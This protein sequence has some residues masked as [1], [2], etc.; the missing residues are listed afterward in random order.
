MTGEC[1]NWVSGR[2]ISRG[3]VT[4]LVVEFPLGKVHSPPYR[5]WWIKSQIQPMAHLLM[6]CDR[7]T[8]HPSGSCTRNSRA[9]HSLAASTRYRFSLNVGKKERQS[10]LFQCR[11]RWERGYRS[12]SENMHLPK[13]ASSLPATHSSLI[14]SCN[15]PDMSWKV[16]PTSWALKVL[17][18]SAN[19]RRCL[20]A[21]GYKRKT[22]SR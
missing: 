1:K 2:R 18:H 19:L 10:R 15:L 21:A 17:E 16:M 22:V 9:S 13:G 12:R 7:R 8:R 11:Q 4:V 6:S 5:G 3:R 20:S 14:C